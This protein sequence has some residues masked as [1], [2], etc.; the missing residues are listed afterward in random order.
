M[1][2]VAFTAGRVN[3][4][5]CPP[6]KKQAFLWDA[7]APGLGLR[8]TPAG[9]PAY[10]FQGV[11]QG[12]D[13][14]ITIGGLDAWSID[15]A[16]AKTRALQRLIDEGKDPRDL[17]RDA[18]AATEAKKA[19][20]AAHAEAERVAAVTVGEIWTIYLE[21]RRS[22]WGERHY[23][24]HV[25][26]AKAGG[27]VSKRGVKIAADGTKPK[28][29]PGPLF[30]LL[31]LPLRDL[32]PAVIE[33][34]ATEQAKTRPTYAR[35]CWRCLKVFLNWCAEHP[36][37]ATLLASANPAKT[38]TAREALGRPAAHDD[39]VE[40]GQLATW[41]S[42]VR[43]IDNPV[44]SAYLQAML[45]TGARPGEMLTL[46]WEDM[47]TRWM[48]M[49]IRDK[50]Q[51]DRV[52]PLTPYVAALLDALPRRNEWVFSSTRALSLDPVSI[53]RR[54]AKHARKGSQAPTG[55]R[56]RASASGHLTD[57]GSAHRCV[58]SAV[59]LEGLTLHGLRRSFS[60]LTEW[61]EI[62]AGVV[63]Q[64][65]GHKPSATAEKHY[66]R[67]PLDLL[68]VHHERIEQWILEQAGINR[69]SPAQ[70]L[71]LVAAA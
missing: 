19:A 18:I 67:R 70:V 58:C 69:G 6:E 1:T 53:K 5:K 21:D 59:G 20:A 10:V 66:K 7:M 71:P 65:Q 33:E 57:P 42:A 64:I 61:L 4:F 35:L 17:K 39:A 25:K 16:R 46:R 37:Y 27:E 8:V 12:K 26:M 24:D 48:S 2:K 14:R 47:D 51:G 13:V 29:V 62:P 28:T 30:H 9:R 60:T 15:D 22:V 56:V 54:E 41:F 34:W 31:A 3:G 52:I 32:T 40:K 23:A 68:R 43:G 50:D 38:K 11:Y 36:I 44:I 55:E 63:A 49:T 45:L